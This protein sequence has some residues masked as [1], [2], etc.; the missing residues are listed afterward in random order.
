MDHF[1]PD[2][3]RSPPGQ[4]LLSL[5]LSLYLSL[6]LFLTRS[7]ALSL[8]L[9]LS[10]SLALSSSLC[11]SVCIYLSRSFSLLPS[12]DMHC[13][14]VTVGLSTQGRNFKFSST[15][16]LILCRE[17]TKRFASPG[18]AQLLHRNV[19]RLR[20]GLVYKAHTLW[21]HSTLGLRVIK[22]KR[23]HAF[24]TTK[25][26]LSPTCDLA[27]TAGAPGEAS[28]IATE[29]GEGCAGFPR[30]IHHCH[31]E[32]RGTSLIRNSESLGPNSRTM[33]RALWC[34][35]GGGLFLMSEVPL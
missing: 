29:Q 16:L 34:P 30:Y 4:G 20:G 33:P 15:N 18:N 22:N 12:L 10:L 17:S 23:A 5:S 21:Y 14:V 19:Q 32:Y 27:C 11:L 3:P 8:L 1:Q 31:I 28:E 26:K 35:W 9:C 2:P 25:T 24:S 7:L 13:G 6:S